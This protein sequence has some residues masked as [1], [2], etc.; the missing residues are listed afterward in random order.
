[1][2]SVTVPK[3]RLVPSAFTN[4]TVTWF[5]ELTYAHAIDTP[6]G[7]ALRWVYNYRCT[8]IAPVTDKTS[9][10]VGEEYKNPVLSVN[11]TLVFII[12]VKTVPA[13]PSL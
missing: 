11:V 6:C 1:M 10:R 13:V 8:N 2:S 7:K 5:E 9:V 4:P 3:L 12:L